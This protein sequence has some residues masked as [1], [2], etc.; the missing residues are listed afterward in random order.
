MILATFTDRIA[1]TKQF[2]TETMSTTSSMATCTTRTVTI[3]MIMDLSRWLL[4]H[5]SMTSQ[6]T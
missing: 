3:A 6:Q 4:A 2:H 1:V 5:R